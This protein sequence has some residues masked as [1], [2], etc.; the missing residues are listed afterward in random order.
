MFAQGFAP[1]TEGIAV[2]HE[3]HEEGGRGTGIDQRLEVRG[4]GC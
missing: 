1:H 3:S 4:D 2:H